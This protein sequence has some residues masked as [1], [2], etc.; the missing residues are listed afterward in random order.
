MQDSLLQVREDNPICV[1][2]FNPTGVSCQMEAG[3]EL[4]EA[5]EAELVEAEQHLAVETGQDEHTHPE[6]KRV[7]ACK[8]GKKSCVRYI[9]GQ[10]ELLSPEQT[11]QLHCF[12]G[13]NHDAFSLDPHEQG[14]T[15][16]L[17]MEIET[18]GATP[19]KQAAR[20]MP[21][22]I[23]QAQVKYEMAY[24]RRSAPSRVQVGDWVL[25]RF[26]QE[27]VGKLRKLSRPWHG[28]FRV[29]TIEGPD[30]TVIKVYFPQD[31]VIRVHLSR[32]TPCPNEFPP[33]FYWYWTKRHSP[34]RPPKWV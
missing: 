30:V 2:V 20:R 9:V 12:L 22:A 29:L 1:Q 3:S 31:K 21:F 6:V 19:K 8:L 32:V 26:L 7:T 25:V 10:P 17:T 28:P 16:L 11:A 23:K 5:M 14:E 13:E 18:G 33:G 27:E 34:G 24:D 4:G 15:D